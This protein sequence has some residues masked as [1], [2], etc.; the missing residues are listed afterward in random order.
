MAPGFLTWAQ[1]A[2]ALL[3]F[4]FVPGRKLLSGGPL[5]EDAVFALLFPFRSGLSFFDYVESV[6]ASLLVLSAVSMVLAFTVGLSFW[7]LVGGYALL[8]VLGWMH[9]FAKGL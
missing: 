7:T 8:A 9:W 2:V 1:T 5:V 6:V 3:F 4:L